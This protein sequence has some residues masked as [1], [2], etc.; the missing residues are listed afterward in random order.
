L[1]V[2]RP[3]SGAASSADSA[4]V[5]ERVLEGVKVVEVGSYGFVPSAGA[6]LAEWGALVIKVEP[7]TGGDPIRGMSAWGIPPG[8]GGV[9]HLWELFNRG[10]RSVGIDLMTSSG[11]ELLNLL[12]VDA[13]VFMT[14]V[15]PATRRKMEIEVEDIQAANPRII[16]ARGS[17]FGPRG[18]DSEKGGFDNMSYWSRSGAAVTSARGSVPTPLPGPGFGDVQSGV[19]LAGGIAA[20][21]FRRERTGIGAVVDVSLLSSGIWAM[22][23]VLVGCHVTRSSNI[24]KQN[25]AAPVNPLANVYQT[26]D[27]RFISLFM[28]VSDRYWEGFCHAVGRPELIVDERF[29]DSESRRVNS[30][31][32]VEVLDGLFSEHT[33]EEW[34]TA[35]SGQD[36]Q[37]DAVQLPGET[38]TDPQALENGYLQ[39][40]DYGG[41]TVPLVSGPVQFD[42]IP[43][44][45][46]RAP[47]L[48]ASTDELLLESG[49]TQ[50]RLI[51]LKLEGVI[52]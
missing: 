31:A 5:A 10:K 38:L 13:D 24:A 15:L 52:T 22:Q 6:I 14:N 19:H 16:Y 34:K 25:R 11:R 39:N 26:S 40:V 27:G 3:F 23:S 18:P 50:E 28:V 30:E 35:L 45:L 49:V 51:E 2:N 32:C 47:E 21:L 33:L 7:P 9:T 1:I 37:W 4:D 42:G 36:G 29:S 20:A 48:G 17:G 43:G 8:T 46:R 44:V 12:M 41:F